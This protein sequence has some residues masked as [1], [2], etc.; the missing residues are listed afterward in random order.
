[1]GIREKKR[2][3]GMKE[4]QRCVGDREDGSKAEKSERESASEYGRSKK[5]N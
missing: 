3:E 1:M 4:V 2:V 5:V